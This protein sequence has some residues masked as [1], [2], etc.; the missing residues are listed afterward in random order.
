MHG[1]G[2][3]F[4]VIDLRMQKIDI[5]PEY[6]KHITD[7]HTGVGCD[8]LIILEE[9]KKANCKMLIYNQDASL[10]G[11]CGNALRCIASLLTSSDKRL[12]TIELSDR[13]VEA[14][15][16]DRGD[17]KVKIGLPSFDWQVIP[18]SS[19]RDC[20]NI[21]GLHQ[22]LDNA[23]VLNI[24]NPHIVFFVDDVEAININELGPMIEHNPLFP[25]RINVSF[26]K[27]LGNDNLLLRVWERGVGE[28]L[29][30]GSAACAATV[31]A[32]KRSYVKDSAYVNFKLGKLFIKWEKLQNIYMTGPAAISFTGQI[33][34]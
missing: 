5:L 19:D 4:V 25:E 33:I 26:A 28:T 2:N 31:A 24:G 16:V 30:C 29:A 23:I 15:R 7:R 22:Q 32:V 17:I 13:I 14:E 9:S 11:M 6:I 18:L 3:D 10:S 27:Y 20:L 12:V 1:L 34:I 21:T 8:Q